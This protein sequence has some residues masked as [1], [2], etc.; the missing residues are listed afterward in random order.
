LRF[1]YV[2]SASARQLQQAEGYLVPALKLFGHDWSECLALLETAHAQLWMS[3]EAA[4]VSRNDGDTLEIWAC[5]GRVVNASDQFL[6]VIE[7]SARGDGF[8]QMR[9]TGRKGWTRHLAKWGWFQMGND[10]IKELND[11]K[12]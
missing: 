11:G 5:G 9:I 4:L 2:P 8:K 1:G 6:A 12:V 3:D 10:L 7:Q